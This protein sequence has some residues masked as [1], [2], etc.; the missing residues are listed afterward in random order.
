MG[1]HCEDC[2]FFKDR[3]GYIYGLCMMRG[4]EV[5]GSDKICGSFVAVSVLGRL[6]KMS[7]ERKEMLLAGEWRNA[8]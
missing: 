5:T 6:E 7:D 2:Q 4:I 1:V 3:A 8:E